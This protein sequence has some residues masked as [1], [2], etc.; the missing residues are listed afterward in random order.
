M[1]RVLPALLVLLAAAPV[2]AAREALA[3]L[4]GCIA[5]L[6][7]Q[8]DMGY[9]R[10]AARCP[11]LASS[12]AQSP[13]AAWL[14]RGWDEPGPGDKLSLHGLEELR[15][16]LSGEARRGAASPLPQPAHLAGVLAALTPAVSEQ[17]SWWQ[18]LTAW[19]RELIATREQS[20][21]GGSW[22]D[23]LLAQLRGSWTRLLS[24]AA[25]TLLAVLAGALVLRE[26]GVTG[27]LRHAPRRIASAEAQLRAA[28]EMDWRR[29]EAAAPAEQPRLLLELIS[30]R[31][32]QLERLPP[33]RALTLRELLRAAQLTDTADRARLAEL[34]A[35]CEQQRF[36]GRALA[37]EALRGALAR[38]RELLAA[39]LEAPA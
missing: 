33:A 5:Q 23:A 25:L 3:A 20:G 10:I 31:L 11:D 18:R 21:G 9:A 36:S 34:A 12:L 8:R 37:A 29:I 30:A 39:L 16:L 19:L 17:R 26:L 13:Y 32:A 6:D 1:S 28:T 4:D 24:L 15:T 2:A 35:A 14:P 38:G 7:W 22:I 27:L